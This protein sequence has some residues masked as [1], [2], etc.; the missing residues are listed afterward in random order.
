MARIQ[1]RTG[2]DIDLVV[3]LYKDGATFA[4]DSG[5][6]VRAALADGGNMT[7]LTA[8]VTCSNAGPG[9]DWDNS[10]VSVELTSA[11]TGGLTAHHL[12]D[13]YLEIE[14]D[15]AVNGPGKLR[16]LVPG[17]KIWQGLIT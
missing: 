10:K 1:I 8:V 3:T 5:A 9:A 16:W 2:D 11:I 12:R 15:D 17:L 7:L 6:T 4:I 13:V 14:V